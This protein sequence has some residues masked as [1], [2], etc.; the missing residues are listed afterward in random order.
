MSFGAYPDERRMRSSVMPLE[1]VP[2]GPNSGNPFI[3]KRELLIQSPKQNNAHSV[4]KIV[5]GIVANIKSEKSCSNSEEH[6][7][8]KENKAD[9][10][11]S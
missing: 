11:G 8:K 5:K 9:V 4:Q 6:S 10:L 1:G 7:V 3:H 2:E